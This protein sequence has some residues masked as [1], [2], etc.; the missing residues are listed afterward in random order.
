[1]VARRYT[2]DLTDRQW[3]HLASLIHFQRRSKWPLREVVN[4]ILYVL[5]NG[6]GWRDVPRDF[7]PY[8]TVYSYFAKWSADGTWERVSGCLTVDAR[9]SAQ[10]K[11]VPRPVPSTRKA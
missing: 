8:A 4:A 1:M 9:E 2:S 3:E 7:P 10:K 6:S 11:P 5:K